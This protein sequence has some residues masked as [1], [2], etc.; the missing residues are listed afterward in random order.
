M[1]KSVQEAV[2]QPVLYLLARC[3]SSSNQLMYGEIRREDIESWHG[4]KFTYGGC[5]Y[6]D[7]IRFFKG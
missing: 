3:P 1:V 6:V 7:N 2:E 4:K 5:E